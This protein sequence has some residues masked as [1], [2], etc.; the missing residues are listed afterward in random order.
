MKHFLKPVL[1]LVS[2][3]VFTTMSVQADNREK[4]VIALK[5]NDFELT[6]TDISELAIGEAQT[7]ETEGGR[8]IDILRT[9][10]GA[11]IYVDGEL[12]EMNFDD[13]GPHEKHMVRKQVE[14]ICE[15]GEE[16]D[17][18]VFILAGDNDHALNIVDG[19]GNNIFIHKEVE[20]SCNDD[21]ESTS[22]SENVVWNSDGEE[23]GLEELHE[24]YG[25]HE[26]PEG[27]NAHKVIVI[28]K[29]IITED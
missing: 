9:I 6:E 29:E 16:C 3:A 13:E 12:L 28:R 25:N 22:C 17:K 2:F 27:E 23:I 10:D 19:E 21:E 18:N 5:T 24:I 20:L 26:L 7:I 11:E 8:V 15:D 1:A 14:V 4:M